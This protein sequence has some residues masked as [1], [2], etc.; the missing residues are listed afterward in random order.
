MTVRAIKAVALEFLTNPFR[1]RDLPEAV[2]PH[3][4]LVPFAGARRYPASP[5]GT[6]WP[7]NTP[8][9]YGEFR[10]QLLSIRPSVST[11]AY[12]SFR[13]ALGTT[14]SIF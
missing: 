13:T 3:P 1:D 2:W 5:S 12:T 11:S 9:V 6:C 7:S 14:A 8:N 10:T 4:A